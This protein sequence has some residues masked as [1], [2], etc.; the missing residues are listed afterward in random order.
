MSNSDGQSSNYASYKSDKYYG[1]RS[2]NLKENQPEPAQY[3]DGHYKDRSSERPYKQHSSK[4]YRHQ[5]NYNNWGK[6]YE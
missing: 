2:Y 4:N 3:K 5:N 1:K 6:K